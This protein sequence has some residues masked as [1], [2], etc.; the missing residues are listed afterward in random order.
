MV[1]KNGRLKETELNILKSFFPE[2]KEITLKEL[3][4]RSGY[5]YE[6]VYRTV[7]K[8]VEEKLASFKQFGK[9]KVYFLNF[10]KDS[11][12]LAFFLYADG[13]KQEFSKKHFSIANSLSELPD[14]D[15][16]FLAIFG[17]YAKGNYTKDSDI[18]ILS[19]TN[20]QKVLESKI[21]SLKY[22]LGKEP[23]PVVI[24]RTE[25]VKIKNENPQFWKDLIEYGVIFKGYELFY[26]LAYLR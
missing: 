4:K 18:D 2:G 13:K 22:T 1:K 24:P 5:S 6:P 12:K 17:S 26:Y 25:F 11:V 20:K 10:E 16:D 23:A 21:K 7:K 14:D 3:V 19:V 9:T 15:V 8:L